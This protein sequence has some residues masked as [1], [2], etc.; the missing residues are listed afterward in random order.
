MVQDETGLG[1]GL[2]QGAVGGQNRLIA[3]SGADWLKLLLR[4]LRVILP[5]S[6][7][8][9]CLVLLRQLEPGAIASLPGRWA[10]LAPTRLGAALALTGL[11]LWAVGRYDA[12]AHRHL[13]TGIDSRQARLSGSVAIAL[14]QLL[15]FGILTGALARWRMLPDLRPGE[16]LR[17]SAFVS[18]SFLTA[19]ALLTAL[20][21]LLLPA[22]NWSMPPALFTLALL[23]GLLW[24]IFARL[25]L[26][27]FRWRLTLPSLWAAGSILFWT[28]LDTGTAALALYLLLPG[29]ALTFTVFLPVFLL[30]LS[31]ALLCGSPGGVGPFELVLLANL[32]Q[33]SLPDLLAAVVMFRV[34]YYAL[35][36]TLAMLAMIRPFPAGR[37]S[38]LSTTGQ[39]H[40]APRAEIGVIR[41]NGGHLLAFP[42]GAS[43]V[44]PTSQA[45]VAL[46][47][48]LSGAPAALLPVLDHAARTRNRIPCLYKINV[49]GSVAARRAGWRVCHIADEALL[50]PPAFDLQTRGR[51]GLRRKLRRAGAAGVTV[52]QAR[53]LPLREMAQV[54]AQWQARQGGARGGTMGFFAPDYLAGQRVLLAWHK[55]QLVGFASFHAGRREWCLD[56][57]RSTDAAPDGTMQALIHRALTD[58]A[59]LQIPR[60]SLAA[61]PACPD[62]KNRLTRLLSAITG[63]RGSAT[64]L[65]RFKSAFAPRWEPLYAA[66][67]GRCGLALALADI[68]LHIH[69]PADRAPCGKTHDLHAKN[70]LALRRAS[71][72]QTQSI[73]AE[74]LK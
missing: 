69:R 30:A 61:V 22:P 41:Q 24:L 73:C 59:A 6:V 13:A 26:R 49:R 64:G 18:F 48:P 27:L 50:H 40:L 66:A 35:P 33:L 7:A 60:F 39:L 17:L 3:I 56:L 25:R 63:R 71:W 4:G 8:L 21:C 65:R 51:R 54:D 36:A 28:A 23:P 67:P 58:A 19:L 53:H 62:P 74:P 43:A 72:D 31:A 12:V 37:A 11:S 20:A 70:D 45:L 2:W 9:A 47:D 52:T 15:G 46:F 14:A 55:G 16:A 68:A 29:D 57:M 1:A 44:W 42:G 38:E 34:I 10:D 5:C 32:P